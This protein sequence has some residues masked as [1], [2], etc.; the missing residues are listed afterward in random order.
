MHSYSEEK[1]KKLVVMHRQVSLDQLDLFNMSAPHCSFKNLIAGEG[2]T[3]NSIKKTTPELQI[4]IFI[5]SFLL[6]VWKKN[7]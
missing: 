6:C 4:Y 2:K 1:Q 7:A 5:M 3:Q